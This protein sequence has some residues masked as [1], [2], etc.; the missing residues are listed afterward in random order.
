MR[1]AAMVGFRC[2]RNL[3]DAASGLSR[4]LLGGI[5]FGGL[6]RFVRD[7]VPALVCSVPVLGLSIVI[8]GYG[9]REGY[10]LELDSRPG[11]RSEF[12]VACAEDEVDLSGYVAALISE[13]PG[14]SI[15]RP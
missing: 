6:D 14:Y 8:S 2:D 13:V 9:G 11:T 10:G 15:I 5:P 7:E 12:R 3:E 4:A 1:I